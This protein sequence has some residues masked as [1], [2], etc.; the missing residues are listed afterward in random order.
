LSLD[1]GWCG[2]SCCILFKLLHL[3]STEPLAAT[4]HHLPQLQEAVAQ[5][6][7]ALAANLRDHP[8]MRMHADIEMHK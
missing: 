4:T 6:D 8:W 7:Y 1:G 5:E 3:M 2:A